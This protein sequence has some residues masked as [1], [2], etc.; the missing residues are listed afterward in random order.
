METINERI[1]N[2][3]SRFCESNTDFAKIVGEK[4]QT[5]SNWLSRD[6]S[7][8][9]LNKILKAFPLINASWL[10]TGEGDMLLNN[11]KASQPEDGISITNSYKLIPLINMDA[12]GGMHASNQVF[13][14]PEY[15]IRMVAFND[16]EEG[17]KCI[18]VTGDSMEPACPPGSIVLIRQ[19]ECWKEYFGFGN[20]FVILLKDGRR[21]LKKV[22]KSDT[23][24]KE[25]VTCVSLN[26]EYPVE[27]LPKNFIVGVWKV[28]KI[29]VN[30]GW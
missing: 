4:P 29:L 5:V 30:R 11:E 1:S 7:K 12:V 6:I 3:I 20:V 18:Q 9:T 19:V 16:A 17:D 8:K 27:D 28:I 13:N 23:D 25:Y 14:E 24:P 15:V 26:K 21:I 2:I 22:M 10:Y